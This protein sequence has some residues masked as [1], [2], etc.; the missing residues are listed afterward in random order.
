MANP[1]LGGIFGPPFGLGKAA[2]FCD[3]VHHYLCFK[4]QIKRFSL[5]PLPDAAVKCNKFSINPEKKCFLPH[6]LLSKVYSSCI[7]HDFK[8]NI[9]KQVYLNRNLAK[10][11]FKNL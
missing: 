10:K 2:K 11:S 1:I 7:L 3:Y 5:T 9:W 8:A 6:L 4:K